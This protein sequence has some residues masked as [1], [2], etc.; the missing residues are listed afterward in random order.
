M[1]KIKDALG[2]GAGGKLSVLQRVGGEAGDKDKYK[3]E[4][5]DGGEDLNEDE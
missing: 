1:S 3:D 2:C 4:D 5:K